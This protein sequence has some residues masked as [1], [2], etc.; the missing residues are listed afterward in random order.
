MPN[1]NFLFEHEATNRHKSTLDDAK[2]FLE[3]PKSFPIT[4]RAYITES[5]E[6]QQDST[7]NNH[8]KY[9]LHRDKKKFTQIKAKYSKN[10]LK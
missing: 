8:N 4:Q 5:A 9:I 1:S 7:S 2:A 10:K 3:E 6:A